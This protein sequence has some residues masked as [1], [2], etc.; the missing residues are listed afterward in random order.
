MDSTC[1]TWWC[2]GRSTLVR[3][4]RAELQSRGVYKTDTIAALLRETAVALERAVAAPH[5]EISCLRDAYLEDDVE[6]RMAGYP[7]VASE[8]AGDG[9]VVADGDEIGL[10]MQ[11]CLI[12]NGNAVVNLKEVD[13]P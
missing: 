5:L 10:E 11:S 9:P 1:S 7:P 3:P 4:R 12:T 2:P 8:S 6:Q 13:R